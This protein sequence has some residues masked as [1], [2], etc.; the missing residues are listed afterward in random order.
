MAQN[1]QSDNS[2]A[3]PGVQGALP[4][5]RGFVPTYNYQGTLLPLTDVKKWIRVNSVLYKVQKLDLLMKE[6]NLPCL[7]ELLEFA[8]HEGVKVSL[9]IY[10]KSGPESVQ[11]HLS[12]GLHDVFVC[13]DVRYPEAFKGWVDACRNYCV[14]FRLQLSADCISL[15]TLE[16]VT[17]TAASA[18]SVN[19]V[20]KDPFALK[21]N[22]L[23]DMTAP[24][25]LDW[26]NRMGERLQNNNIETHLI[27]VPFC[28]VVPRNYACVMNQQQFFLDHQQYKRG[29]YD[30]AMK[31]FHRKL[32]RIPKVLENLLSR[33]NSILLSYLEPHFRPYTIDMVVSYEVQSLP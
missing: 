29:T 20:L 1:M 31:L 33:K 26:M 22:P 10:P 9:R 12:S 28:R 4:P 6:E 16:F 3:L 2:S 5:V 19:V 30:L 13:A 15:G 11:H 23:E 25:H 8:G 32:W 27:G 17:E 18:V 24:E 7:P 14:P 21:S